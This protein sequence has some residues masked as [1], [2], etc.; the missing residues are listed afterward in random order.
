LL[1]AKGQPFLLDADLHYL[2]LSDEERAAIQH[3]AGA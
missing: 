1:G 2:E 3:A